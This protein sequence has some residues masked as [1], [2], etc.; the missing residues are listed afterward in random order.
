MKL[1]KGDLSVPVL[2]MMGGA[3]Y[4]MHFG[5]ANDMGER[6]RK[7]HFPCIHWGIYDFFAF[8]AVGICGIGA[9]ARNLFWIGKKSNA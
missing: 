5:L 2:L 7:F 1:K 6:K 4:S 8:A 9:R 3:L